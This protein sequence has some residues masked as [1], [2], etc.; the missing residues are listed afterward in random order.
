M[1]AVEEL[2]KEFEQLKKTKLYQ[3]SFKA[4]DDCIFLANKKLEKEKNDLEYFFY[5]NDYNTEFIDF[6]DQY[7]YLRLSTN[8]SD[9]KM[10]DDCSIDFGPC[11][12][13]L[14]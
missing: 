14:S 11:K 9:R 12:I 3:K 5:V 6:K 8:I 4:I 2:I 1:T 10:C 7:K 13:H